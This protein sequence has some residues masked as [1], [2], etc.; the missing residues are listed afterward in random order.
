MQ[1]AYDLHL[2]L[3]SVNGVP[4]HLGTLRLSKRSSQALY[5]ELVLSS[6]I[7]WVRSNFYSVLDILSSSKYVEPCVATDKN[8]LP[9]MIQHLIKSSSNVVGNSSSLKFRKSDLLLSGSSDGVDWNSKIEL[10]CQSKEVRTPP[11]AGYRR[12]SRALVALRASHP[13]HSSKLDLLL[14]AKTLT[15]QQLFKLAWPTQM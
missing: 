15:Q 6:H 13:T 5:C 3:L 7:L 2:I 12:Q 11:V 1:H 8:S 10:L 4:D 9:A 14:E